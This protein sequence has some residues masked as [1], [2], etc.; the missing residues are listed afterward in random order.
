M[1]L[2][3]EG[4][5]VMGQAATEIKRTRNRFR[6]ERKEKGSVNAGDLP[7]HKQRLH[8]TETKGEFLGQQLGPC[9][10][11]PGLHLSLGSLFQCCK[12]EVSHMQQLISVLTKG[13]NARFMQTY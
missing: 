5:W 1:N 10:P 13:E 7:C 11:A 8:F 3:S 9:S 2:C 12:G 4:R 6:R